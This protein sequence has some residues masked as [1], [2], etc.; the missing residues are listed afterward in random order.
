MRMVPVRLIQ[1]AGKATIV[2]FEGGKFATLG[3]SASG[4]PP[5]ASL[6]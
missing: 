2:E 3:A 1:T 5:L 4:Q 6:D